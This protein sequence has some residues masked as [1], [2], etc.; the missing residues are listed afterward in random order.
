MASDTISNDGIPRDLVAAMDTL[1]FWDQVIT[2]DNDTLES[3]RAHVFEKH[4]HVDDGS[5]HA[6]FTMPSLTESFLYML[7]TLETENDSKLTHH[8]LFNRV[9]DLEEARMSNDIKHVVMSHFLGL[10]Q[11]WLPV[12]NQC[13]VEHSHDIVRWFGMPDDSFLWSAIAE[14][15]DRGEEMF[16]QV[17]NL[18]DDLDIPHSAEKRA[19]LLEIYEALRTMRDRG[20]GIKHQFKRNI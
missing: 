13:P 1:T 20:I 16:H 17:M 2:Y 12:E 7:G 6:F 9:P 10:A 5:F 3:I 19:N 14:D 15:E 11:E 4:G 18:L 8:V